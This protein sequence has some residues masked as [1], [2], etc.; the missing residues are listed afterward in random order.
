MKSVAEAIS[1]MLGMGGRT[2]SMSLGE[3]IQEWSP[4]AAHFA[5]GSNSRVSAITARKILGWNPQGVALLDDIE[6]GFYRS[7]NAGH[8]P[9]V[10]ASHPAS[11][12]ENT[13]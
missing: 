4:E 6:H 2:A 5:F 8:S 11:S 1:R 9:V 7:E 10:A 12:T 13:L 3:A